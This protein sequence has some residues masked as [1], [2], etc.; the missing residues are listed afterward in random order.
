MMENVNKIFRGSISN[1]GE[2]QFEDDMIINSN[3]E[4]PDD[5]DF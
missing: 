5:A 2:N 4:N 1:E 3:D